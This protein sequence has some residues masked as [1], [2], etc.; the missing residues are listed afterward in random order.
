MGFRRIARNYYV[1]FKE[2]SQINGSEVGSPKLEAGFYRLKVFATDFKKKNRMRT[3]KIFD[4]TRDHI[5]NIFCEL[6]SDF[7]L[8]TSNKN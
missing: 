7:R 3:K 6:S 4:K 8:L 2:I 5:K 1:Y